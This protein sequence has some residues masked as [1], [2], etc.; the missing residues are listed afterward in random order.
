MSLETTGSQC[1]LYNVHQALSTCTTAYT[2]LYQPLKQIVTDLM[3]RKITFE[4]IHM[5]YQ[6]GNSDCG[7]FAIVTATALAHGLDPNRLQFIVRDH[8]SESLEN[9]HITIFPSKEITSRRPIIILTENLRV[10]CEYHQSET[11]IGM[12]QC[13]NCSEWFHLSCIKAPPTAV[14]QEDVLWNCPLCH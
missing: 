5:Q 4:H 9:Q 11:G 12:I 8:L 13:S 7:L 10:Y 3:G 2:C 1:Q 14:E 6:M